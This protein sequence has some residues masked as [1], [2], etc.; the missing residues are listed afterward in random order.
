[1]LLSAGVFLAL[2]LGLGSDGVTEVERV[3][4]KMSTIAASSMPRIAP[5]GRLSDLDLAATRPAQMGSLVADMGRAEM[6]LR[7][8]RGIAM[9]LSMVI[10][11]GI[12]IVLR[13]LRSRPVGSVVV[14]KTQEIPA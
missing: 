1:M 8:R 5:G 3:K 10:G 12:F 4:R 6:D 11:V 2:S 7:M 13:A 9:I 14:A